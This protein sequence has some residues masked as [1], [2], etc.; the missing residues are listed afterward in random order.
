MT[1]I[2]YLLLIDGAPATP[3]LLDS[4][5][6]LEV[7]DHADMADMLRL[8]C[9]IGV[10]DDCSRWALLDDDLFPRLAH[11][12]LLVTVGV[13]LPEPLI[14][15]YVIETNANFANQPGQSVL[16]VVAMDP[17]VLMHLS[18]TVRPWSNMDDSTIATLIFGEY[19]FVPEVEPTFFIRQE[20]EQTT[21]QRGTD[22]QFLREL[23]RR[24]GFE[25]YVEVN[26]LTQLTHGHFHLPRLQQPP[27]GVLSVNLG[28]ATNVNSFSARYEMLRPT[29]AHAL[30]LDVGTQAD[31]QAQI[32]QTAA[33][34]LGRQSTVGGDR[35]RRVLLNRTGVVQTSELQ[36]FAQGVVD[37]SALAIRAEGEL[38]TVAYGGILRAKRPVL[39]RGAGAQFSGTYYVEKVLHTFSGDQYTQRF[40]LRRNAV[41]LTRLENFV[42]SPGLP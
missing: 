35:P 30:G 16:N 14:D 18:E 8:N 26:P 39:V 34:D 5:Q 41:G 33:A 23:A 31:Q 27:Q 17:T 12:K 29:T 40:T 32:Q 15:A 13:N 6:Q 20:L 25:V 24:N 7:E 22:M 42:E 21:I 11:L 19:G 38:N 28:E 1:A 36:T 9:A 10:T 3:D 37:E 4:L 2:S